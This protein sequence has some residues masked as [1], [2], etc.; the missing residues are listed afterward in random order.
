[1]STNSLRFKVG[2]RVLVKELKWEEATV[3]ELRCTAKRAVYRVRPAKDDKDVFI[4]EDSVRF[5][6]EYVE[7][8]CAR[9]IQGVKFGDSAEHV[10]ILSVH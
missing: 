7:P 10:N 8:G 6:R 1:M 9:L 2:D 3:V 5:I 4:L